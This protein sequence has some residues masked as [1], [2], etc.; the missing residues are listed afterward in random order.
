MRSKKL[1]IEPISLFS[2]ELKTPLSS[3]KLSLHLLE[4]NCKSEKDKKI[5]K[6]MQEEIDQMGQFICNHL[7]L[8]IL[9][10][11]KEL[12][13]FEWYPWNEIIS[14]VLKTFQLISR[15]KNITLKVDSDS[16]FEAFIDPTW[17]SQALENLLSN[18]IKF[19]LKNTTVFIN[20]KLKTT[21][22]E[23][24]VTNQGEDS[25]NFKN[26]L[27]KPE[28]EKQFFLKSTGLGLTIAKTIIENHGGSLSF[29]SNKDK[30]E[31]K[32]S[33]FIPKAQPIKQSA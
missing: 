23:C 15:E 9:Q 3:L 33:F 24:S 27:F 21:G 28:K 1:K 22:F 2:H 13:N 25:E 26:L 31:T 8:K 7:D 17:L 32:F 16:E 30:K 4:Q 5:I 12:I 10:G 11:N 6:I 20:Y 19:S 14:K 29:H 18:A